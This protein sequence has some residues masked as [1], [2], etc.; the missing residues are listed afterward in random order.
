[1][2]CPLIHIRPVT[3]LFPVAAGL[4]LSIFL[5]CIF[6]GCGEDNSVGFKPAPVVLPPSS[7]DNVLNN[8]VV[9]Y[10]DRDTTQ[11][12][13]ILHDDFVFNFTQE[14]RQG[15]DEIL[16]EDGVWGKNRELRTTAFMFERCDAPIDSILSTKDI[17]ITLSPSGTAVPCN[18]VGAPPGTIERLAY[19]R[20]RVSYK[21]ADA[22]LL[23][24][25][26]PLFYFV[27]D[28]PDSTKTWKIW[29][30]EDGEPDEVLLRTGGSSE[31]F[32]VPVEKISWGWLRVMYWYNLRHR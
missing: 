1:M 14:D 12:D 13:D 30:I 7:P 22:V 28:N 6:T 18:L 9:C 15:Y 23:V 11:L 16:P 2:R 21:R 17:D 24:V 32:P 19:L 3:S 4:L 8:L 31:N 27:P 26:R 10:N 20:L 25:S 29:M 5:C